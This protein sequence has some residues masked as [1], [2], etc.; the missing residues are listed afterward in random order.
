[1]NNTNTYSIS[2]LGEIS[3]NTAKNNSSIFKNIQLK[4]ESFLN[5]ICAPIVAGKEPKLWLSFDQQGNCYWN[6]Y[7]P[8]SNRYARNLSEAEM[9]VWLEERY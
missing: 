4:I 7:D 6:A 1:M 3:H 5:T 9:R 2:N 8:Q